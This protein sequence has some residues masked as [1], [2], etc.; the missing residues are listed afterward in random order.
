MGFCMYANAAIAIEHALTRDDLPQPVERVMV[1]DWDVH[2][3]NGTQE[4]FAAR[5]EVLVCDLHQSGHWP[6]TGAVE[7]VGQGPGRGATLN[8][9]IAPGADDDDACAVFDAMIGPAAEAFAPQLVV[10]C[11]GFD[12]HY[13]DPLGDLRYGPEGFGRLAARARAIAERFAGGRMLLTLE[14][15]YALNALRASVSATVE[16]LRGPAPAFERVAPTPRAQ[17]VIRAHASLS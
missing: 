11:A 5:G 17:A 13:E 8:L 3:G 7:E 16:A 9:P 1:I 2:H 6:G 4:I 14:G 10:V 12:A 15:G